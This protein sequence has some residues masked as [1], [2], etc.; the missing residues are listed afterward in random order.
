MRI[1]IDAH[2]IGSRLGGNETYIT[3]VLRGLAEIDA[4]PQLVI[5]VANVTAAEAWQPRLPRAEFRVFRSHGSLPRLLAELPVRATR[6]RL[7]LLHVQYVAPPIRT[8]PVVVTVHDLSYE[9]YPQ[10]FS[11]AEA[12]QLKAG[13]R[14]TT[15]F[16][17]EVVTIS[18]SSAGDLMTRYGLAAE[19]VHVTP[20]AVDTCRFRPDIAPER[21]AEAVARYGLRQPY[22][23]AVGNLQPRK[24]IGRLI[25]A[26]AQFVG[27]RPDVP[28]Q[29][30]LVGKSAFRHA[31]AL[32]RVAAHGLDGRVV[33]TGYVPE[34]DLPLLYRGAAAFAYP[35]IFEGFGLPV[36]EA[37]ATGTP[38]ITSARAPLSE[39][40]GGDAVLVDPED[41]ESIAGGLRRV[42]EDAEFASQLAAA[43]PRRAA[44]FSWSR[45]ARETLAVYQRALR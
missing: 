40:A 20:L 23:L 35:S 33:V 27:Q 3:G 15:R 14:L 30:A 1:G 7:D 13:V 16:A 6:D 25:D 9:L 10:F 28:H 11:R 31:D 17:R 12:L 26:F 34:D 24:N 21:V 41:T 8:T 18:E 37:M 44:S 5:Y 22:L 39:L 43:G 29:L 4:S 42:L 45:T 32:K 36:L 38:V 2:A 19:R